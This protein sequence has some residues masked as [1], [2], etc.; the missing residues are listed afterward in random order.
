MAIDKFF[1]SLQDRGKV[2]LNNIGNTCYINAAVQC[3]SHSP[4]LL[5]YFLHEQTDKNDCILFTEMQ[6]LL[7]LLWK[8]SRVTTPTSFIAAARKRMSNRLDLSQQN[9]MGEFL[10]GLV[11]SLCTELGKPV[12]AS[13]ILHLEKSLIRLRGQKMKHFI[14]SMELAWLKSIKNDACFLTSLIFGQMICQTQCMNC[15]TISHSNELFN[16]I[17]LPITSKNIESMLAAHF[18]N[19][20]IT[21][22]MC[23]KCKGTQGK[24]T[25]KIWRL[26]QVLMI[27][28][29][30]F[31]TTGN[32]IHDPITINT[33]ISLN[34]YSIYDTRCNFRLYSVGCHV[35]SHHR[36]HYYSYSNH[37]NGEWYC[38]DDAS[39]S[40]MDV[41]ALSHS[42]DA[43]VLFYEKDVH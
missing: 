5:Y 10:L 20:T 42:R 8:E 30:R 33:S 14:A 13:R 18:E 22:W 2:G 21:D 11:E 40:R 35:G 39:V 24:R 6:N 29:K 16:S 23:E 31:T 36:G 9:D 28:L 27:I 1:V 25:T 26:P 19:E 15:K 38:Y 17:S 34:L 3:L 37:P 7:F 32:K 4:T 41:N 12:D 43:Y